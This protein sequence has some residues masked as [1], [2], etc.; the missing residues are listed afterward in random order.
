M[1]NQIGCVGKMVF[2][3][4]HEGTREDFSRGR[5][6]MRCRPVIY[7]PGEQR[8][9]EAGVARDRTTMLS[10]SGGWIRAAWREPRYNHNCRRVTSLYCSTRLSSSRR[11]N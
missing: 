7:F 8:L 5:M 4:R 2:T 3:R 1:M 9:A 10:R 6:I 11:R